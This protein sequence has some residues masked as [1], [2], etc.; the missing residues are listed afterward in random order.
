MEKSV[1]NDNFDDGMAKYE[2][3]DASK[4]AINLNIYQILYLH[5]LL[6]SNNYRFQPED[7]AKKK[8][9]SLKKNLNKKKNTKSVLTD[10][11]LSGSE[12]VSV[13][14]RNTPAQRT[15]EKKKSAPKPKVAKPAPKIPD[16]MKPSYQRL[17]EVKQEANKRLT[18]IVREIDFESL[19]KSFL[20]NM[21]SSPQEFESQARQV[22]GIVIRRYESSD[23]I[24]KSLNN[25]LK[26]L[27]L[28]EE[29][30]IE[31]EPPRQAP[32]TLPSVPKLPSIPQQ[33]NT[34]MQ[35]QSQPSYTE[36]QGYTGGYPSETQINQLSK[37][38][39]R[40]LGNKIR[41]LKQKYMKGIIYIV[42]KNKPLKDQTLEFDINKLS[43][44]T[45]RE[46]DSYVNESLIE[47][48][49]EDE[50]ENANRAGGAF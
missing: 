3:V 17:L 50:Q 22:F 41:K 25:L 11:L 33:N 29:R 8:I 4:Y 1:S 19:E 38:E 2:N 35:Q 5:K 47:Q 24:K 48:G 42:R 10:S 7:Y 27:M 18:N 23:L 40:A 34:M 32:P 31:V 39:K 37:E 26:M 43:P 6:P 14:E 36:I 45:N 21:F 28:S 46:L 44:R 30:K 49:K 13:S 20:A 16:G 12:G 15:M 9:Q